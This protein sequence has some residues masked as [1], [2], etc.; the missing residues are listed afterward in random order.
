[1]NVTPAEPKEGKGSGKQENYGASN[2]NYNLNSNSN[3]EQGNKW[4]SSYQQN[5][6]Y[7]PRNTQESTPAQKDVASELKD[8]L[9]TLIN[10]QKQKVC[11]LLCLLFGFL[12][13]IFRIALKQSFI[14]F[15]NA[16]N[17]KLSW[18]F[19]LYLNYSCKKEKYEKLNVNYK[20][21]ILLPSVSYEGFK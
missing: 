12:C 3:D 19:L 16:C 5:T 8:M 2:T 7:D 6:R 13:N 15:N 1:M 10:N 17:Y 20:V 9:L 14:L 18:R 21:N 4:N 11:V